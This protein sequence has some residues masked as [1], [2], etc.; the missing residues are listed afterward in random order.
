MNASERSRM[1]TKLF[2][3]LLFIT[4]ALA[5][6]PGWTETMKESKN[7]PLENVSCE[8]IYKKTIQGD[9]HPREGSGK[10]EPEAIM[11]YYI[12]NCYGDE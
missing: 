5:I 2:L 6:L 12:K 11:L 9:L 1:Y 4:F 8:Y 3:A 7:V 10:Y